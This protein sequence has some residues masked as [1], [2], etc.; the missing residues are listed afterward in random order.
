MLHSTEIV[1]LQA[2]ELNYISHWSKLFDHPQR[3]NCLKWKIYSKIFK[4]CDNFGCRNKHSRDFF[5]KTVEMKF[6]FQI[7]SNQKHFNLLPC[8]FYGQLY[9]TQIPILIIPNRLLFIMLFADPMYKAPAWRSKGIGFYSHLAHLIF[10]GTIKRSWDK[11]SLLSSL[12]KKISVLHTL[13]G[14]DS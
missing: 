11:F 9:H 7:K 12:G 3:V 1:S 8:R 13:L 5:W 14:L 4:F 6:R 2:G 10:L